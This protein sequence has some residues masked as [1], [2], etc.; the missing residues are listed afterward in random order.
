MNNYVLEIKPLRTCNCCIT[1]SQHHFFLSVCSNGM[2]PTIMLTILMYQ[3]KITRR[4]GKIQ[5][6]GIP[7]NFNLT[8]QPVCYGCLSTVFI[9]F[10]FSLF[11]PNMTSH[12]LAVF[13]IITTHSSLFS[14]FVPVELFCRNM[15]AL[16][17]SQI[18]RIL[19]LN[20]KESSLLPRPY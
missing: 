2:F 14:K 9:A 11:H 10:P 3:L 12:E 16:T 17:C 8:V 15:N 1:H 18:E 20:L 19:C 13:Y 5:Y 6:F 4:N 7:T